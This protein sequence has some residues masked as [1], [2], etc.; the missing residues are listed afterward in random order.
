MK[1]KF[2]LLALAASFTLSS[3]SKDDDE[4]VKPVPAPTT[5]TDL[6]TN[7]YWTL[8]GDILN[9]SWSPTPIDYYGQMNKCEK[10]NY[11]LLSRDNKL[12]IDEGDTKCDPDDSQIVAAG[13]WTLANREKKLIISYPPRLIEY[14]I[15]TLTESQ[16]VLKAAYIGS[17]SSSVNTLT[18]T[19]Q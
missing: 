16:L 12:I 10:D 15:L 9:A 4:D 2:L 19:A 1:N 17:S 18:Y 3:C 5:K 6:L 11:M 13:T 8:T 14:E 7:K